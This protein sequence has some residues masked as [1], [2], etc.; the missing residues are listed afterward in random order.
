MLKYKKQSTLEVVVVFA[1]NFNPL[2]FSFSQCRLGL[3]VSL[4][5]AARNKY[6]ACWLVLDSTSDRFD[7]DIRDM[8]NFCY[9]RK[10]E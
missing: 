2:G 8:M 4:V 10:Y 7:E 1:D 9:T 3:K 5:T 6:R